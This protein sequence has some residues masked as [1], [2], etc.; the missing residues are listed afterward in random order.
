MLR[1]ILLSA[2]SWALTIAPALCMGGMLELPCRHDES[3]HASS[4]SCDHENC[5]QADPCTP[6]CQVAERSFKESL[7]RPELQRV[8]VDGCRAGTSYFDLAC[9]VPS[10][11]DHF[12]SAGRRYPDRALPL[13]I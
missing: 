6:V 1:L 10:A 2:A 7:S 13:L 5:C 12:Y 3:E 9:L 4:S 8:A 11:V